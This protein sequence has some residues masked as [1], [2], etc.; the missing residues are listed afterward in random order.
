MFRVRV[1]WVVPCNV[2]LDTIIL[3]AHAVFIIRVE[4]STSTLKMKAAQSSET[5]VSNHHITWHD[6]SENHKLY[7]HCYENLKSHI[8]SKEFKQM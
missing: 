7:L 4:V 8:Q 6:N 3:E 2:W 1:F 5:V